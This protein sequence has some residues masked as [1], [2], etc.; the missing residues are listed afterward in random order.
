MLSYELLIIRGVCT[1]DGVDD[2]FKLGLKL[3][4]IHD[5]VTGLAMM[6]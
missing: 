1:Y 4:Y 6:Q 3:S 2:Q 5:L